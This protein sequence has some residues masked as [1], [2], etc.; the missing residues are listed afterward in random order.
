METVTFLNHDQFTHPQYKYQQAVNT[1]LHNAL[2]GDTLFL[3]QLMCMTPAAIFFTVCLIVHLYRR[4][5]LKQKVS[6]IQKR[7]NLERILH[8]EI[9][10]KL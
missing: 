1:S 8:H 9:K 6:Q 10:Q 2:T 7:A 5:T 4:Y 3:I